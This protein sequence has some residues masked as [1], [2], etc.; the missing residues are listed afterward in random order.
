M[1]GTKIYKTYIENP[2]GGLGFWDYDEELYVQCAEWC[3]ETQLGTIVDK[4]DYY[5][6]VAIPEP[7]LEE[8]KSAKIAD[9]KNT[10]D[11]LEVEPIEYNGSHFDYDE[12][13]R[14]RIN[15][16]IIALEI[17]GADAKLSWTT[18]DQKEAIV[19][20][21]DLRGIIANVALRSNELHVKYRE[22]KEL[23][24]SANTKE[25]LDKVVWL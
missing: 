17:A 7:S 16:A 15:A 5:E 11:T 22:L 4:D 9:L 6:V 24:E 12:K 21:N 13:A 3:N 25:E 19:T 14:D 20:A 23:V 8:I 1:L 2:D 18:A 10:R